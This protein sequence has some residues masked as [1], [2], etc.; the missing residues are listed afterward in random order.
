VE[1][2]LGS[3]GVFG[4]TKGNFDGQGIFRKCLNQKGLNV[5]KLDFQWNT[6]DTI[7]LQYIF[8]GCQMVC[9]QTKNP[10]WVNL[11]GSYNRKCGS[12]LWSFRIFYGNLAYFMAI[13]YIFPRFGIFSLVLVYCVKKNLASL[14]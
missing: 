9:F 8:E 2:L 14:V 13:W 4:L 12:I 11:G 3:T 7:L 1:Q 10:I 5:G 6:F